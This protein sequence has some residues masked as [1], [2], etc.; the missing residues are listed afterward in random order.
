LKVTKFSKLLMLN[1]VVVLEPL[2]E[3]RAVES[4]EEIIVWNLYKYVYIYKKLKTVMGN[5]DTSSSV[6]QAM[7]GTSNIKAIMCNI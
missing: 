4:T 7:Q 5:I 6:Q 2:G 1:S 3:K